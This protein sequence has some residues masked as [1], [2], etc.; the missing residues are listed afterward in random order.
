MSKQITIKTIPDEEYFVGHK[1]CGGCGGSLVLR[2]TL[3]ALGPNCRLVIPA[4][5]M[6]AIGFIYP[7]MALGERHDR[8]LR[9]H[10][11]GTSASPR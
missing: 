8:A 5:C 7:Q 9:C 2:W 4:G 6:S 1:G 3:K 11:R 10:R